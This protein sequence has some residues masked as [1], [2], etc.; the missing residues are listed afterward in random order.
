ME[1]HS[2][3]LE[4]RTR[5]RPSKL[6]CECWCK[7]CERGFLI[8]EGGEL[9]CR[10]CR[11]YDATYVLSREMPSLESHPKAYQRS[12]GTYWL[13]VPPREMVERRKALRAHELI[14]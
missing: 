12:D 13:D 3:P 6:V 14:R 11:R 9:T 10:T 8:P 2:L 7:R 1:A 5:F 4:N